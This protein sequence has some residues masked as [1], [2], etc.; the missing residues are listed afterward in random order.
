MQEPIAIHPGGVTSP[1]GFQAAG[2]PAGIKKPGVL[3]MALIVSDRPA[4]AAAVYTTNRVKAAPLQVTKEHI[5]A[6][7]L[8]AIVV[9]AGNANA[10]TGEQGLADARATT[11][12]VANA[13][14]V[15]A[16]TVAVAST[17]VIGQP[18]PMVKIL[19]GVDVLAA[20]ISPEGGEEA[21]QA[22]MTTDLV[23]KTGKVEIAL[24]GQTVTIGA[25]AKGSGMIHPNMAT[26]LAFYTTDAN[27]APALLQQ[28][29]RAA[30]KVSYNM[31]SVDGD[32]STN[33]MAII[34]ANGQSGAPA[35][36]AE[37]PEYAAF[38]AALTALSIHLAKIM[39]R[40][41]EG[42]TKL[43]EARVEGAATAEDAR[44]AAMAI[45]KSNLFKC[46]VF[47]NDANWGRVMCAIGY[48]G[49]QFDPAKVDV[50]LGSVQT[51]RQGMAL[52]FSEEEASKV[53]SAGEVTVTVCLNDGDASATAWGC[54]LTYD[55]VKINADYRS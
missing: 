46:A 47:G 15:A 37:G 20:A 40:D 19:A 9:N 30:T 41:G 3:D 50:F 26:M 38:T 6:G 45:I 5:A 43:I 48:S 35:I 22:I 54:D 29:L 51:A 31:I 24:G 49:A 2:I 34:L 12:H 28:A 8:K 11:A 17:G 42:A 21:A 18:L 36:E 44:K 39:A 23:A 25:M 32:T 52:P 7:P 33:D 55:Y 10:C 53:L 13:L 16:E 1:K 4:A 27:I 14:G